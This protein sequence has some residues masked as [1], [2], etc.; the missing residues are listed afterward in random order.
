ME[1]IFAAIWTWIVSNLAVILG[2]IAG[3]GV[4]GV[5]LR[6]LVTAENIAVMASKV[7]SFG[8]GLG[9]TATLG[10]SHWKYTKPFW[11]KIVEPYVII[12]FEA[13]MA[14]LVN[15]FVRGLESDNPS[16]SDD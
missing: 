11:N 12:F 14:A 5:I 6:K 7:D 8:Y 1:A 16:M 2:A 9:K 4:L 13:I 10:L 15:G 3:G